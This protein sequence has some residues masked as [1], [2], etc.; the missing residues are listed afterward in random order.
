VAADLSRQCLSREGQTQR[1]A[2]MSTHE[3]RESRSPY[4]SRRLLLASSVGLTPVAA[5]LW[6]LRADADP[7][8]V[9]SWSA[10]FPLGGAAIHATLLHNDDV[11]I[12]Q[13]VEGRPGID[14]T[15]WIATWNWR[16]GLTTEAPFPYD[17]DIFC[18][19]HNVLADGRVFLAG[20]HDHTTGRRQDVAAIDR[21]DLYDPVARTWTRAPRLTQKRWYPTNVAL[22]NGRTLIFGG[23]DKD[24]RRSTTVDEYNART[25]SMRRLP[26][27]DRYPL[28]NYPRMHLMKNGKVLLSGWH[29]ETALFNPARGSWRE[30]KASRH[31]TRWQGT[32]VLLPGARRVLIV[33]GGND[34]H[35]PTRTA[36]VLDLERDAPRWRYTESLRH[37]RLMH[38]LVLLP[39][40]KALAVGGGRTPRYRDPV[41]FP[42]MYNPRTGSWS[43]MAPQG[44]SRMYH[45]TSLLLPDGRVFSAGQT[46]GEFA[47]YGEIYS[48]PYLFRGERPE[49]TD[50]PESAPLGGRLRFQ[51]AEAARI[52]KV[53]LMRPSSC[54]HGLDTEQRSVPLEFSVSDTTVTAQVPGNR[55]LVPPG[56]YMFFAVD[57]SGV[58]AVAPWVRIV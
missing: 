30:L 5:S 29:E 44:A 26:V 28:G 23:L 2:T 13:Y 11:L 58:P 32:S 39:D 8:E 47:K 37:G 17:R 55:H 48:P 16:T 18:T 3:P 50:L 46:Y 52:G 27:T 10:P 6:A 7:A 22:G 57:R 35:R 51:S 20:G 19:G 9:G 49:V 40:G 33:G 56:H 41:F 1:G 54:T 43:M 15:S 4:L 31:G 25:N 12:F 53:T 34:N 45:S 42:E 21:C 38:N 36:E 14:R 24:G